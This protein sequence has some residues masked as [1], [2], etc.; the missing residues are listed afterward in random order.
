[1]FC[2]P[3]A[4]AGE[5]EALRMYTSERC[6]CHCN[7]HCHGAKWPGQSAAELRLHK[8]LHITR[9]VRMHTTARM[10]HRVGG[11][12]AQPDVRATEIPKHRQRPAHVAHTGG[13]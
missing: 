7:C 9:A 2:L 10:R 4:R 1:M 12:D 5:A 8:A 6:H 3:L 11:H 13:M